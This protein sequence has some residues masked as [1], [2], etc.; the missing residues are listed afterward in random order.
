MAVD[1]LKMAEEDFKAAPSKETYANLAA[2]AEALVS[3]LKKAPPT[4]L[5]QKDGCGCPHEED[6]LPLNFQEIEARMKTAPEGYL[7]LQEGAESP[8]LF[9]PESR[10]W[11][12][13][14]SPEYPLQE[15]ILPDLEDAELCQNFV[16]ENVPTRIAHV[17]IKNSRV[18]EI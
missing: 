8:L 18:R 7:L 4:D 5:F 9:H 3:T 6:D 15:C 2:C 12:T 13:P 11:I 10:S 14:Q 1:Y 17:E 16:G